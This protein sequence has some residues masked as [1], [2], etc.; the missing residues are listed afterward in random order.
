M[1]KKGSCQ[2]DMQNS[3]IDSE[4]N[5]ENHLQNGGWRVEPNP[6]EWK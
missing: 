4:L 3:L 1:I 5:Y 2:G 6:A